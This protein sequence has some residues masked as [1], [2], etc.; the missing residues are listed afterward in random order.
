MATRFNQ[1]PEKHRI[2]V[3]P[4]DRISI[5]QLIDAGELESETITGQKQKWWKNKHYPN[6]TIPKE[7]YLLGDGSPLELYETYVTKFGNILDKS[8]FLNYTRELIKQKIMI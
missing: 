3:N 5:I 6:E 2:M 4:S 7:I 8:E 1:H